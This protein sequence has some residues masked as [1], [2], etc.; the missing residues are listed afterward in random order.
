MPHVLVAGKLHPSGIELLDASPDVTFDYVEEVSEPSYAPLIGKADGL[1]IRT[2]PL[3][4]SRPSHAP[5]G[6][7]SS[8]VTASATT[9]SICPRSTSAA[10]RWRSVGDVNSVSVAEHAMMLLLAAAKRADPRRPC[11]CATATG[12]GATGW[13]QSELCGQAAA[14]RRLRPER[15]PPRAHGGGVRHGGPRLRSVPRAA[16]LAGGAGRAGE[17]P[18]RRASPGR[19]SSPSM[20]RRPTGR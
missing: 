2:Q 11:R 9:R 5:S 12:A 3:L 14:D 6:C 8:R 20:R 15:P 16:R 13:S 1:V 17:R 7:G 18:D 10:S 19:T 4:G